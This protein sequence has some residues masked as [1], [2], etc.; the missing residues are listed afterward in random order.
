MEGTE[1]CGVCRQILFPQV[2][3][4]LGDNALNDKNFTEAIAKYKETLEYTPNDG[5]AFL[6]LG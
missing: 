4:I 6:R 3:M 1:D 2:T 5:N